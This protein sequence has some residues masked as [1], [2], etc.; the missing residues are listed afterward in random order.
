MAAFSWP[1]A[2]VPWWAV[3]VR[4]GDEGVGPVFIVR[5]VYDVGEVVGDGLGPDERSVGRW[6]RLVVRD[7]CGSWLGVVQKFW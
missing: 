5:P 1:S 3:E 2:G 7:W 6:W 4:D